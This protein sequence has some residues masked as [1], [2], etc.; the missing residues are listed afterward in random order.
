MFPKD[1][2]RIYHT[3]IKLNTYSDWRLY[4]LHVALFDQDLLG[5]LTES[6]DF[7]LF[8]VLALLEL[9]DPLIEIKL[10]ALLCHF[11][12]MFIILD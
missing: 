8:D 1:S 5:P 4:V 6:L 3:S 9:L 11:Q 2:Y 7:A 12:F 10:V